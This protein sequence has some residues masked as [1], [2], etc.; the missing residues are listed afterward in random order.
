[1]NKASPWSSTSK[2]LF[3]IALRYRRLL[4]KKK[5]QAFG[6]LSSDNQPKIARIYVINLERQPSRLTEIKHE[7]KQV[8]DSSGNELWNLT[9][10]F[11]AVDARDFSRDPID[12]TI[13]NSNYTLSD[14]LFVEPQPL[15]L[16][17][18]MDLESPIKMSRPEIAVSLSHIG[19]W[20]KFMASNHEYALILEDDVWF[21]PGFS[22]NLNQA[23]AEITTENKTSSNFDVLYL[24]YEEVKNGAPK[25]FV[26]SK[27]FRPE[28]GLWNLSG[29][30][31]SR[32][33]VEKLLKSLPCRGPIDLWL[34]HQF[35]FLNVQA[36]KKS[37]INQR[38]DF[39]STNSY[40][41]LPSLTK[42]GA[43]TSEGAALFHIRPTEMPV[44]VFGPKDSGLTSL[45]MALSMLGYRCCSDLLSLPRLESEMLLSGSDERVFNAYVNI[46]S[47]EPEV[48]T[49]KELYPNAKFIFTTNEINIFDNFEGIEISIIE[50]GEL[51]KWQK[52]CS[53]L[54]CAPPS[55]AF[56]ELPDMGQREIIGSPI[57]CVTRLK[58]EIPKRDKSPW[59][60][61]ARPL[62][63]GIHCISRKTKL[64]VSTQS[65]FND[66][67]KLISTKNW[68]LREDTF[69][70]NMA[71]FRSSNVKLLPDY[72]ITLNIKQ[73]ALGV[74]EYSAAAI[75]SSHQYL[76][77][78][79]E[80]NIKVSNA[81]GVVTGFFLHRDSPRQEIDI[82]I[83][84]NRPDR[85]V[86][87]VF[88][89][90]GGEGAKFDYGY[91]GAATYIDL[92]FDASENYHK[93]AIEW[94]S[95]NI[96]WF[97][98]NRLVHSRGNWNPTPIPN[99]P[100]SLHA[101]VWPC[102]SKELA[103]RIKNRRFPTTT[104]IKS[105]NVE[106]NQQQNPISL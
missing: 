106:A 89:N 7:L 103:G 104:F 90:P 101:N 74:R 41:V 88:Y 50:I 38:P 19:V 32:N 82:E 81:S 75:T 1:M 94:D 58:F 63:Q 31:V 67:F 59:V 84:G 87:N 62:W 11:S 85:L 77:G 17:T 28:R 2:F 79:F 52:L 43:I 24:S 21:R 39:N 69:T 54:R 8:L 61:E 23:W 66:D 37:I 96:R 33:G 12:N 45:A 22:Q 95:N 102:R 86:I 35:K 27:V 44:F 20:R 6:N 30:V 76:F 92:G 34:N 91:R 80:A 40:S 48:K 56:P 5:C 55:T 98:D 100:M 72:G 65:S 97:V 49:I 99:L 64:D 9:E 10:R 83:A 51:D 36:V 70:D 18:H 16:P 57:E 4:P 60:V 3:G 68:Y 26:S 105:I 13:I 15:S 14:Q 46:G 29:Y 42:I 25:T 78:R 47:L 53:H 93:Y 73:E 71:L